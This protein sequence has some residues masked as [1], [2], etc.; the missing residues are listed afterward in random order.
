MFE[1]NK[2]CNQYEKLDSLERAALLAEKSLS[3]IRG[4]RELDCRIDPIETLVAFIIGSVVSD[5]A[6]SE[7]DYLYIYPSLVKAF[8]KDLDYAAIK[9][10]FKVAGDI[11]KAI[12]RRTED[13]MSIIAVTDDKLRTDVISLCLLVT[14]VDGKISFKEKRYIKRLCKK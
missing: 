5:G 13:L 6:V 9:R 14:S 2:I 3:V 12:D 11:K 8:G 1:F 7:K 4:L 10:S